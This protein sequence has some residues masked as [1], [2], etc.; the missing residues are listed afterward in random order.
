MASVPLAF[1]AVLAGAVI[2]HY[3]FQNAKSAFASGS[4]DSAGGSGTGSGNTTSTGKGKLAPG[5]RLNTNQASFARRLQADTGLDPRVIE[6]WLLH[7]E[8]ASSAQAPNGANNWLNIGAFDSGNWAFGGAN[9]WSNPVTAADATAAFMFGH[10]VNGVKPPA[11]GAPSIRAILNSVGKGI[12]AEALAIESS[13][14]A[15][16]HYGYALL[17]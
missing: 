17:G 5:S 16:S 2:L 12:A 8:P 13:G 11:V 10:S 1:G 14:W 4:T 3:G 7:E 15:S 9:V 6:A